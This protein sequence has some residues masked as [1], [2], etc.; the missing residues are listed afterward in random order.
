MD[1]LRQTRW[2]FK[3]RSVLIL[4]CLGFRSLI[5]GVIECL[6]GGLS[7]EQFVTKFIESSLKSLTVE[8]LGLFVDGLPPEEQAKVY[9]EVRKTLGSIVRPWEAGGGFA[10]NTVSTV[11]SGQ[12]LTFDFEGEGTETE[13]IDE[14]S[15][16]NAPT[17]EQKQDNKHRPQV[18]VYDPSF[19]GNYNQS[20]IGTRLNDVVGTFV[21]A[22]TNALI[23]QLDLDILLDKVKD[24]PGAQ[25]LKKVLFQFA[26][27]T[28]PL[29]HPPVADFLKSFSLQIC[30][31]NVG[32]SL[33]RLTNFKIDISWKAIIDKL[34]D[35]ILKI[36]KEALKATLWAILLKI[37][38]LIDGLLCRALAG[39]G[40]F[41]GS[42]LQDVATGNGA[43]MSFRTAMREAFCGPQ[44][45]PEK[46]TKFLMLFWLVLVMCQ[47]IST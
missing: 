11:T 2:I 40:K 47:M 38:E 41:V 20:T 42:A 37:L 10:S 31:P 14:V 25:L 7:F 34:K 27:M 43:A 3:I 35:A 18:D 45:S 16:W 21:R 22:Y 39:V 24:Y 46:L 5:A 30:N 33:P 9:D 32:L 4:R 36:L 1:S 28:P 6:L 23:N 44:T 15:Q 17:R 8:Q 19:T 13:G 12:P 29:T 26:C